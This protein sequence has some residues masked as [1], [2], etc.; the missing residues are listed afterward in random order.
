VEGYLTPREWFIGCW[1]WQKAMC[2]GTGETRA[3]GLWGRTPAA[4]EEELW[5]WR[6]GSRPKTGK[7]ILN[8]KRGWQAMGRHCSVPC[9]RALGRS[10]WLHLGTSLGRDKPVTEV[11]ESSHCGWNTG[12]TGR[13]QGGQEEEEL[14]VVRTTYQPVQ[15][16]G[17]LTQLPTAP[18]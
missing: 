3:Q 2:N 17:W 1:S 10:H 8:H 6:G 18:S 11:Q 14:A 15:D 12:S 9:R 4:G 7:A 13:T 5:R 16:L